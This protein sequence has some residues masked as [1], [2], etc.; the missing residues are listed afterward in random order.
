MSNDRILRTLQQ[1]VEIPLP[2]CFLFQN[3]PARHPESCQRSRHK[4]EDKRHRIHRL[5]RYLQIVALIN[6][7]EN[8]AVQKQK[9]CGQSG[10]E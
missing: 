8:Q 2:V 9:S 5:G 6:G 10:Q 4:Q 7:G 1:D 3:P